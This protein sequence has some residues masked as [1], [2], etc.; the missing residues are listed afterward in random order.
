MIC[1]LVIAI[2]SILGMLTC[3]LFHPTIR[4]GRFAFS[5][6]Y[7]PPLIGL[8]ILL[9][10]GNVSGSEYLSGLVQ[11]GSMNPLEI[12][13]L[14]FSMAFLS[15]VLD[16]VGFFS[17]L[18]DKAV[19]KAKGSQTAL[20]FFLYGLCSILTMF[21]SNDIVIISFTPFLLFFAKDAKVNPI[22]YLLGEFVAANTWSMLFI[23][24]NPT[25]VYLASAFGL[26]FG[27]YFSHMWLPTLLAG[28]VSLGV[29]L[30]LFW[31]DLKA[32]MDVHLG[33]SK[34]QN[35][36]VLISSLSILLSVV[37]LMALSSYIRLPMWLFSMVGAG[38]LLLLLLGQA[39]LKREKPALLWSSCKRLPFSLAPFLLAM[40][41]I[42]MGLTQAGITERIGSFLSQ[43][44]PVLSYGLSSFAAAN[45]MNNLPMSVL[46]SGLLPSSGA[47]QKAL[48]ATIASSNLG[49]ILTPVGAL[50]G[51]LWMRILKSHGVDFSFAKFCCYGALI[52]IPTL[53]ACLSPLFFL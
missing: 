4:I 24:G 23:F 36:F 8:A 15:T 2:L 26:S 13:I 43:G 47:Y 11:D 48:Y 3:L 42:V 10:T 44:E 29:M 32:P 30:L 20:F 9:I 45:V 25:N 6:F 19:A 14:F 40:F 5:T 49:A 16:E 35:R 46:Y 31:K 50:A 51:I 53:F 12:L 18:A 7:W 37:A 1:T 33:S 17:F 21:T 41:G 38:A 52:S 34:I 22:P 39:L 27:E 28:L